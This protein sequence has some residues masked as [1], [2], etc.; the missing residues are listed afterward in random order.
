MLVEIKNTKL[1]TVLILE[2][3]RIVGIIIR[4]F[5]TSSDE[6]EE[7]AKFCSRFL[8]P[9]EEEEA[10]ELKWWGWVLGTPESENQPSWWR[11]R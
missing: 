1:T 9:G 2:P 5:H 7:V 10:I 8:S 3:A 6:G 4:S 11:S